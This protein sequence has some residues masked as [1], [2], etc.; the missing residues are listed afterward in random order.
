MAMMIQANICIKT[1]IRKWCLFISFIFEGIKFHSRNTQKSC[2]EGII[3]RGLGNLK[4]PRVLNF[5]FPTT[6]IIF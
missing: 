5:A 1:G 6:K 2:V 3:F 4:I